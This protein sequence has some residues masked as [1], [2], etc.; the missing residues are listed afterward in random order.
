M[1]TSQ[2]TPS[3]AATPARSATRTLG[4]FCGITLGIS[5]LG[6]IGAPD[7]EDTYPKE[8]AIE[9]I[10][11]STSDDFAEIGYT[12]ET[13]GDN[14]TGDV[15]LPYSVTVNKTVER[16]EVVSMSVSMGPTPNAFTLEIKVDG[17]S[18]ARESH[19]NVGFRSLNH[20]F[21]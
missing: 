19:A 15:E 9:Y 18:V 20:L 21:E 10:V 2:H 3:R 13:G 14:N 16:Y 4:L 8:V 6:C 12:N 11:T 1:S 5:I 7:L 17:E